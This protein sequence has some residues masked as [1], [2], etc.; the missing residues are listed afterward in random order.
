MCGAK[1][2]LPYSRYLES[3][4]AIFSASFA[5]RGFTYV[6]SWLPIFVVSGV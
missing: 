5:M 1:V 2:F 4:I 3:A 6:F